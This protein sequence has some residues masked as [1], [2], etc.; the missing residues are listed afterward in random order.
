[1]KYLLPRMHGYE[2]ITI[3]AQ[4]YDLKFEAKD[5][6]MIQA[7]I[8]HVDFKSLLAF[9]IED[10]KRKW[11]SGHYSTFEYIM[12]LNIYAGRSFKEPSL[13]P[14]FPVL[15][16][17]LNDMSS[18][19]T[20]YKH[21]TKAHLRPDSFVGQLLVLSDFFF[22]PH[23]APKVLPEWASSPFE[24][25]YLARRI[26]ESPKIRAILHQWIDAAFGIQSTREKVFL[27][28]HPPAPALPILEAKTFE[29]RLPRRTLWSVAFSI[30]HDRATYGFLLDSFE[31]M[32]L[33]IEMRP[34]GF[35]I[36]SEAA[37]SIDCT[38]DDELTFI[39]HGFFLAYSKSKSALIAV[40]ENSSNQI[41]FFTE[42]TLF[43]AYRGSVIFCPDRGSVCHCR[44]RRQGREVTPICFVDGTICAL[45]ANP[46]FRIVALATTDGTIFL[47][48]FETGGELCRYESDKEIS[49]VS[50]SLLW[51]YVLVVSKQTL[52]LFS[53][54]GELIKTTETH[55]PIAKL[56]PHSSR[57][58][59][60]F[61][62][63]VSETNEIGMFEAF[64]PE[65]LLV[66]A[67][68][69]AG[70]EVVRISHSP[71]Q[72]WFLVAF[73]SGIVKILP[74][75]HGFCN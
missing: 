74:P 31:I 21:F 42:T 30:G 28:P 63:F 13:Y 15:L 40:R 16:T 19:T 7:A 27:K 73:T 60:D 59:S 51:G 6:P 56:F 34:G 17:D 49:S 71:S 4:T 61:W 23:S 29:A 50:I 44:F 69:P 55:M 38:P 2:L 41:P 11:F 9:D 57:S 26:L 22:D 39:S 48:D 33:R 68:E 62:S 72:G 53:P 1:V 5:F 32:R 10:A 20:S 66:I 24:F 46:A 45:D 52:F 12:R 25:I 14:V 65:Q 75:V 3:E 37:G 35:F 8:S 47:F 58:G 54:N 67:K 36:E 18:I 70:V 64:Y 43:V